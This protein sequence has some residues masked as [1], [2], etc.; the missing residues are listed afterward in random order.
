MGAVLRTPIGSA[1]PVFLRVLCAFVVKLCSHIAEDSNKRQRRR[2]TLSR[3]D[4]VEFWSRGDL[5]PVWPARGRAGSRR[6]TLNRRK[7][8]KRRRERSDQ[9]I[10]NG[11]KGRPERCKVGRAL[12]A[13]RLAQG[14][15]REKSPPSE[16]SGHLQEA[17][18]S[19]QVLDPSR[20]CLAPCKVGGVLR[21]PIWSV[22]PVFLRVLRALRGGTLKSSEQK[23][24]K[25]AKGERTQTSS[26]R[27]RYRF[28]SG[29]HRA[30][31]YDAHAAQE[32]ARDL[33]A[34][35]ESGYWSVT[36]PATGTSRATGPRFRHR[37]TG[38]AG[39][40]RKA[41]LRV[42]LCLCEIPLL[43]RTRHAL[44]AL[45]TRD[46]YAHTSSHSSSFLFLGKRLQN[47]T[48]LF[49]RSVNDGDWRRGWRKR[50]GKKP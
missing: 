32:V 38:R 4:P 11:R 36:L 46:T 45:K 31:A 39:S 21:T 30:G 12:R 50:P 24:A 27:N 18:D 43:F 22:P 42:L 19:G 48:K 7:R 44:T 5:A 10:R 26:R 6:R 20:R 17:G 2:A 29:D 15:G 14:G 16:R 41:N 34:R 49:R 47:T 35:A 25:E 9:E 3:S 23:V 13:R 1:S 40:R 28:R 8:K 33:R 37:R